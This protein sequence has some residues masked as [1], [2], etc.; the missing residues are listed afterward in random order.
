LLESELFGHKRGAFTGAT[1]EKK[2]LF[3]VADGG[4]LFLDEVGEMP[5]ALQA[6]LLRVLQEGEV[7]PIGASVSR[8]VNVRIVAATNRNLEKE[9]TEG[10]F[11]E[12]LYYRLKVFPLRV[13]SLRERREDVPLLA[14]HRLSSL[15][16]IGIGAIAF[17]AFSFCASSVYVLNDLL[18]LESDRQHVR[19][20]NRPIA[21]GKIAV[22]QALIIGLLLFLTSVYLAFQ[23]SALFAMTLGIYFAMSLAYSLR[24][25]RQ[26]IVDVM[27]LAA[28]YTIRV[29]A[30]AVATVVVPSFWL[31]TSHA[32][33]F[34]TC[35]LSAVTPARF[36]TTTAKPV[37]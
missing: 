24:L 8:R 19:K 20:R 3:E 36:S 18:D 1:D 7:R 25:K 27:L 32:I 14:A 5:L 34:V 10:R 11:R 33:A 15:H 30:G 35:G 26:V 17:V 23:I 29:V 13:P 28:L 9:V 2:G 21:S 12:D 37:A 22:N 16:D 4:T 6:K 31:L